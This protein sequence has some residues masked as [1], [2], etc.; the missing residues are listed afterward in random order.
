MVV[1][2]QL[3]HAL[4]GP[5]FVVIYHNWKVVF[6]PHPGILKHKI[7]HAADEYLMSCERC[8]NMVAPRSSSRSLIFVIVM[9]TFLRKGALI[10]AATA[11]NNPKC[12]G[13]PTLQSWW[14]QPVEQPSLGPAYSSSLLHATWG[15][16]QAGWT[17]IMTHSILWLLWVAMGVLVEPKS[18]GG[19][20]GRWHAPKPYCKVWFAWVCWRRLWQWWYLR[21]WTVVVRTEEFWHWHGWSSDELSWFAHAASEVLWA[22]GATVR[23]GIEIELSLL[24]TYADKGLVPIKGKTFTRSGITSVVEVPDVLLAV[25]LGRSM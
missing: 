11:S 20:L 3:E 17:H 8:L 5:Q 18:V 9:D 6:E 25:W 23:E 21:G 14:G 2:P 19:N 15:S 1:K 4:A 12:L 13:I 10:Q 22:S 16:L 7:Q 24:V